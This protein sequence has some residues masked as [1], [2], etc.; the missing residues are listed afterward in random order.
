MS[1]KRLRYSSLFSDKYD[2]H[3]FQQ[4]PMYIRKRILREGKILVCKNEDLLYEIAFAT[5]KEFNT[6]SKIYYAYLESMK[7]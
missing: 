3:L 4:L 2:I 1:R 5:I 7:E 6:Y